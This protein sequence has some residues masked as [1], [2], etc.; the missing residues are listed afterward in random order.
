MLSLA[1]LNTINC[2]PM[3]TLTELYGIS[4]ELLDNVLL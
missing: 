4:Q 1:A 2:W 3:I